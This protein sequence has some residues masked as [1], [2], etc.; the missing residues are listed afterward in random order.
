MWRLSDPLEQFAGS[1]FVAPAPNVFPLE[2]VFLDGHHTSCVVQILGPT[3]VLRPAQLGNNHVARTASSLV[4]C[5]FPVGVPMR[6]ARGEFSRRLPRRPPGT[7]RG[8]RPS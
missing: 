2:P 6:A 1:V 5:G 4:I 3:A 7:R 8:Y